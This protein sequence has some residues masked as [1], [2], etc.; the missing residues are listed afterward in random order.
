MGG[1]VESFDAGVRME[2]YNLGKDSIWHK[3]MKLKKR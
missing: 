1:G 3:V 2:A